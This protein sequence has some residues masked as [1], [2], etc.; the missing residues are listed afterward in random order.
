MLRI[1]LSDNKLRL[2]FTKKPNSHILC[3]GRINEKRFPYF[4]ITN[5]L[6]F[7][8]TYRVYLANDLKQKKNANIYSLKNAAFL[9]PMHDL[10]SFLI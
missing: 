8:K 4:I 9:S 7:F 2:A 6:F 1:L 10:V 3:H 5:I